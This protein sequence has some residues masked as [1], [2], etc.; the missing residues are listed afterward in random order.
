MRKGRSE[1]SSKLLNAVEHEG[2]GLLRRFGSLLQGKALTVLVG[3]VT[4]HALKHLFR[5]PQRLG[6]IIVVLDFGE[7]L[8]SL[9]SGDREMPNKLRC[10]IGRFP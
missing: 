8:Q 4:R 2:K 6:L 10:R 7:R 5:P 1:D 9:F 3:A